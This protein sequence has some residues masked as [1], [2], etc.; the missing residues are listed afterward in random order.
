LGNKKRPGVVDVGEDKDDIS[1][2]SGLSGMSKDELIEM[3]I[4]K[5]TI[6][7]KTWKRDY[8]PAG[9]DKL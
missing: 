7:K 3:L 1:G 8:A 9:D 4:K 6:S 5:G 2:V